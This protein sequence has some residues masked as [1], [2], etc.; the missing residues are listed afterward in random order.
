MRRRSGVRIR[1]GPRIRNPLAGL[2][3]APGL[4]IFGVILSVIGWAWDGK[5]ADCVNSAGRGA[6][7]VVEIKQLEKQT[8]NG[9]TMMYQPVIEFS[10]ESGEVIRY[11]DPTS[12]SSPRHQ[13]GDAVEVVYDRQFPSRAYENSFLGLYLPSVII[14]ATGGIFILAGGISGVRLLLLI[15]AA[16]GVAAYLLSKKQQV[17]QQNP[18]PA[19]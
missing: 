17:D 7:T 15:V 9:Y 2:F 5:T 11:T 1:R 8:D 4:L 3:A 18:L 14:L 6:G 19:P 13:V 12:S 10:T 16:G